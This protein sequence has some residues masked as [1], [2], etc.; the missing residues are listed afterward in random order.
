MCLCVYIHTYTEVLNWY[1]VT[2][3]LTARFHLCIKSS[4][5]CD[6]NIVQRGL[7][8]ANGEDL[9]D[10]FCSLAGCYMRHWLTDLAAWVSEAFV[11]LL[12]SFTDCS[13]LQALLNCSLFHPEEILILPLLCIPQRAQ[14]LGALRWH[15]PWCGCP[16]NSLKSYGRC[17]LLAFS[18][19]IPV[20]CTPLH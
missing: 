5:V 11:C 17:H 7:R 4:F 19:V 13:L 9:Q 1:G 15:P 6:V 3:H 12:C 18:Y 8:C 16:L 14:L 2:S 10:L 20:I